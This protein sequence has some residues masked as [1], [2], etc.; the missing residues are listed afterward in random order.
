MLA[1]A[2]LAGKVGGLTEVFFTGLCGALPA[3]KC[4]AAIFLV[5]VAMFAGFG[6]GN[7]RS[8]VTKNDAEVEVAKGI[9]TMTTKAHYF[10]FRMS[11]DGTAIIDWG[12]GSTPTEIDLTNENQFIAHKYYEEPLN[13][14]TYVEIPRNITIT[15][16]KIT[17]LGLNYT[18]LTALDVSRNAALTELHCNYN[19]LTELDVSQNTALIKL[20]CSNN[21]LS[22]LD[23][24]QNIALTELICSRNNINA[25]D[26][27]RNPA[28]TELR[29]F[30]NRI[31]ELDISNNI[32]LIKLMCDNNSMTKLDVTQNIALTELRCSRNILKELDVSQNSALT[33]LRVDYN[34]LTALDVSQNTAL[35]I[36]DCTNNQLTALD[37]SQNTVLT[38]LHAEDNQ[39]SVFDA[40]QNT[41]LTVLNLNNNLLTTGALNT[42][43]RTLHDNDFDKN[44]FV[45]TNPGFEDSDPNIA[46]AKHWGVGEAI[47]Y[48]I[49][50]VKPL[51]NGKGA[52]E[53]FREFV[54]ENLRYP[55]EALEHGITARIIVEFIIER[56]GS[57]R[58]VRILRGAD[59]LLD[60]EALRVVNSLPKW[61]PG[62][63]NGKTARVRCQLPVLFRL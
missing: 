49:V 62:V 6:C 63:H 22:R 18:R 7:G 19:Y 32:A 1:V 41:M 23:V 12:D 57:I 38:E 14:L 39:L 52:D 24:T 20:T 54:S 17:V 11:G 16:E 25:L 60:A 56:D 28:L 48:H 59:P 21:S 5:V 34:Q 43:F 15:G 51:F 58:N 8:V 30:Y 10:S 26:V 46:E 53:A 44:V 42:L 55:P 31:S 50:D 29:C 35:L 13:P 40:S 33:R 47:H 3:P 4:R 36:L 61:T 27:S 37:V 2:R 9:I 45:T